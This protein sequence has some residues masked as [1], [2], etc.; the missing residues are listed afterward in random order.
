MAKISNAL[1][2]GKNVLAFLDM[3]AH[4]E[5]TAGI[6]DDGYN[7]LVNPGGLFKSYADHPNKLIVV[8]PGLKSTAAGRYQIIYPTWL[9]LNKKI[10]LI[11]FSPIEQDY[12]AIELLKESGAYKLIISG[13]FTE[14]VYAA[15]KIWASLP[16]ANVNQPMRSIA[17]L[18]AAYE[19]SGGT[20]S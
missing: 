4:S 9:G 17:W 3:L 14:S 11:D 1:A 2:G 16:G 13:K 10:H 18:Q 12:A 19:N 5:G 20:L 15:R 7:V 6:G 8:R